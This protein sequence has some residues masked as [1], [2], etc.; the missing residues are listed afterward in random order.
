MNGGPF[1]GGDAGWLKSGIEAAM[2]VMGGDATKSNQRTDHMPKQVTN[3]IIDNA[4]KEVA[5][6]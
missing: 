5:S 2:N 6:K 3:E 4:A 1:S